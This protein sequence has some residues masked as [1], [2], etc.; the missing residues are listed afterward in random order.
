VLRVWQPKKQL[1]H[2]N[3]IPI[4]SGAALSN[5]HL[6]YCHRPEKNLLLS[7]IFIQFRLCEWVTFSFNSTLLTHLIYTYTKEPLAWK[8]THGTPTWIGK[9][10]HI[11]MQWHPIHVPLVIYIWCPQDITFSWERAPLLEST[12][13]SIKHSDIRP[14]ETDPLLRKWTNTREQKLVQ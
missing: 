2:Y 10:R 1:H 3:T 14:L 12:T 11:S 6:L 8:A 4:K 13:T 7:R 9:D 5:L